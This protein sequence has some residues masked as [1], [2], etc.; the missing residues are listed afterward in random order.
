MIKPIAFACSDAQVALHNIEHGY[1]IK[2]YR[3][4][5]RRGTFDNGTDFY[6]VVLRANDDARRYQ[7]MEFSEVKVFGEPNPAA[8]KELRYRVR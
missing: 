5:Q 8:L 6:I 2:E 3:A 1:K 4:S 7:G